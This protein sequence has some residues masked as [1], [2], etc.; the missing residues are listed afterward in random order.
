MKCGTQLPMTYLLQT[1]KT[2]HLVSNTNREV[3]F[4]LVNILLHISKKVL[5][6]AWLYPEITNLLRRYS[7]TK[8]KTQEMQNFVESSEI[9]A[10]SV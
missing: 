10:I 5:G 3:G 6:I 4:R 1:R 7:E 9:S 8:H 2:N